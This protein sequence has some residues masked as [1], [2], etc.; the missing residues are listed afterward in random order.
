[1]LASIGC[2]MVPASGPGPAVTFTDEEV[3]LLARLEHERWIAGQL[4]FSPADGLTD[5]ARSRLVPWEQL[6]DRARAKYAQAARDVPATLASVGFQVLR[7]ESR[8]Q[9]GPRDS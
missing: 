7:N 9:A 1:M 6:P 2:L 8:E 4:A 5:R 3:E